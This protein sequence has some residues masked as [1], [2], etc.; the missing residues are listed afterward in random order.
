MVWLDE[1]VNSN[2]SMNEGVQ[3]SLCNPKLKVNISLLINSFT[4]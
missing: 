1:Q 2:K 4:N 3:N